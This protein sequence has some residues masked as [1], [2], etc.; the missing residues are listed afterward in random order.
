MFITLYTYI[1]MLK[2]KIWTHTEEV[3]FCMCCAGG[4]E[5]MLY[6]A[7]IGVIAGWW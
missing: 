2:N 1:Y 4:I 7:I 3:G 5:S 6:F